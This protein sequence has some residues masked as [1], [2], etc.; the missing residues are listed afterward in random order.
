MKVIAYLKTFTAFG[1]KMVANK[2]VLYSAN[3]VVVVLDFF[4]GWPELSYFLCA[5]HV[6]KGY[7][8]LATVICFL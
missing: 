1:M 8:L 7:A 2:N 3:L 6:C 5:K 4:K